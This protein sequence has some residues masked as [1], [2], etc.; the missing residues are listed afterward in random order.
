MDIDAFFKEVG[1]DEYS[2]VR[3]EDLPDTD[4]SGPLHLVP[5]ARSV[6]VFGMEIPVPVYEA[7]PREKTQKMLQIVESLDRTAA[8]L[9]D[10]LIAENFRSAVVPLFL[11][12][13]V[14][15]EGI[16]GIV[17]LKRIAALGGLGTIGKST[18]LISP[19]YG[20]R[21]AFS[22]IVT[23]MEAGLL[24]TSLSAD[25]CGNC[26]WCVRSCPGGAIGPDGVDVFRCR[27]ISP[28]VPAPLVPAATWL[29]SH[30]SI[31]SLVVPFA[32]RVARLRCSLCVM[33]C[34]CFRAG[35]DIKDEKRL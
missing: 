8:R 26:G 32:P 2:I 24:K 10:R 14:E 13:R 12:L 16:Q 4:R 23:E 29:L 31:Q 5:S 17:R 9:A 35:E 33:V 20:T 19:R 21:L 6:I 27:N 1:I 15:S 25:F 28:W 18:L 30:V 3:I 34:P 7:P 22:G 11:P